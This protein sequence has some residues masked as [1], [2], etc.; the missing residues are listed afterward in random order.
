MTNP[1]RLLSSSSLEGTS[2]RNLDNKDI[3]SIKD[4]MIDLHTGR[5]AYCVLSFGGFLGLGDK[6]FAVPFEA[7]QLDTATEELI[8]DAKKEVLET[9]RGFDEDNWPD[10]ADM[11]FH[12]SVHSAFK[13]QPAWRNS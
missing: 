5:V 9:A 7:F 11:A 3:G 10:F 13:T 6:L 1:P 8:L 4:I 2:V 12:D